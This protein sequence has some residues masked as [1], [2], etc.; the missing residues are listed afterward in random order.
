MNQRH[1]KT[2]YTEQGAFTLV[3]LLV[4]IAIIA[5]LAAI[6]LPVLIAARSAADSAVCRSNVHQLTLGLSMY[7]QQ[8]GAYPSMD[9]YGIEGQ[10]P[11]QLEPFV[12]APLPT[13]PDPRRHTF[14]I[15]FC[16]SY[17]RLEGGVSSI[18]TSY[19]Y[20][21]GGTTGGSGL[22]GH[23][24]T[25]NFDY[26]PVLEADVLNPSEMIAIGDCPCDV[27]LGLVNGLPW[28]NEGF[29]PVRDFNA[30]ARGFPPTDPGVQAMLRRHGGR[31]IIGFCDG[32]VES[33]RNRDLWDINNDGVLRRWDTDNQPPPSGWA[34]GLT[35]P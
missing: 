32:H 3:E 34:A 14:T 24:A 9:P 22:I 1:T 2:D 13:D 25:A 16:P 11:E 30:V 35:Y 6:L 17:R 27:G 4:V 26:H 21:A 33:L 8:I 20:N 5:I 19:A 12:G 18:R 10:W 29:S 31:W 15:W 23:L 7:V 28:L